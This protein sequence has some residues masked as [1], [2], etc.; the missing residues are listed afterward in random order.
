MKCLVI[1]KRS[2][3]LILKITAVILTVLNLGSAAAHAME[4]IEPITSVITENKKV[5]L[6]V[7]PG[8]PDEVAQILY[9]LDSENIRATFF[10]TDDF[11]GTYP[12]CAR[13]LSDSGNCVGILLDGAEMKETKHINDLLAED[14]EL[15]AAATGKN[16]KYVRFRDNVFD[17]SASAAVYSVGLIPVQWAADE[18]ADSYGCGDIILVTDCES[19]GSVVK[20][21]K[22]NGYNFF[23]LNDVK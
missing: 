7:E 19:L 21:L 13:E 14:I 6:T 8:S 11:F 3:I 20:R 1:K 18:S 16:A 2:I 4:S 15:L 9:T 23:T 17:S 10:L 5:A 12:E 22:A